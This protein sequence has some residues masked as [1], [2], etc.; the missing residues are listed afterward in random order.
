MSDTDPKS[1][2]AGVFSRS[3]PTYDTVVP[4][5]ATFA[6]R[7]VDRAAVRPGDRVLDVACGTGACAAAALDA[8]ASVVAG[9]L[10][11]PMVAELRRR[12]PPVAAV[13]MDAEALACRDRVFDVAV[14]GFGV[15]FLPDHERALHEVRRVLRPGGCFA[16]STFTDGRAGF[17]W[18][19]DIG[20]RFL[21]D[22]PP[23][24]RHPL[25]L[26][27]RLKDALAAAGFRGA[28]TVSTVAR[29][30]F[31]DTDTVLAWNWSH[32]AR[33]LLERLNEGQL[34]ELRELATEQLDAHHA[35][36]GGGYELVQAVE[37][38]I[39]YA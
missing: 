8:G 10:A 17:V 25:L 7:L 37:L 3:A 35:C 4:F 31:A 26:A 20:A 11:V 32:G 36:G 28:D 33:A 6:E 5:F 38:T 18:L 9:D 2:F 29:F 19:N 16:A 34:A 24:V 14:C 21:P 23:R 13:A 39:A 1:V 12:L 22:Q 15:F 30:V 27:A